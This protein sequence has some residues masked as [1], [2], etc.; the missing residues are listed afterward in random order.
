ME[1]PSVNS[2][3]VFTDG[4]SNGTAV[5]VITG[6]KTI[7]H[8]P[9]ASAQVVELRAV[10][11]VFDVM[12]DKRFNLYTDSQYIAKALPLLETVACIDT[13]NNQVQ[14]LFAQVQRISWSNG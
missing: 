6:Q 3:T 1:D 13:A 4:S 2:E 8:T 14:E 7:F 10:A 5:Y 11:S 12:K 9:A